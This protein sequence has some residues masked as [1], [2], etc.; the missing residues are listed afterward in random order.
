ME[1]RAHHVLIGIF[2]L[3][4]FAGILLMALWLNKSGSNNE[5]VY[6]DIIFNEEVSG[7]TAGSAVEYSGIKVG[8][9]ESL[10]LDRTDPRKVWAHARL[11]ATTPVKQDTHARLAL[12]NITGSAL[13]RLVG[14]SPDSPSLQGADGHAP[15]IIADPSPISR[16]LMNGEN[17]MGSVNNL[18]ENLNHLFSATNVDNLSKTLSHIEQISGTIA[19]QR[20]DLAET[21][22]QLNTLT[23]QADNTMHDLSRL[24]LHTDALLSKEGYQMLTAA[25]DSLTALE[26]ATQRIDNLVKTHQTSLGDGLQSMS[27]LGPALQELRATLTS[28]RRLSQ[29]LEDDPSG[30]LL[31]RE[32]NQEF[33]P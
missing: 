11:S 16:F 8:E 26:K 5:F 15:A 23:K 25:T 27:E 30:F 12:A 29:R 10:E 24:A 19:M 14:G 21:L 22:H 31:D 2:I 20:N 33:Q 9:V 4:A 13:I 18:T 6:Y 32:K 3:S 17:L 1:T 28:L 7:L